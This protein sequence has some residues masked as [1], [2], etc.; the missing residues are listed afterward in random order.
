MSC[1]DR[2]G[3][4]EARV[5]TMVDRLTLPRVIGASL[6]LLAVL[7]VIGWA[8]R[9]DPGEKPYLKVLGGGF[10]FNY[11]IAEVYYGFTAVV[12]KPL[13]SGSIIEA[14]FEDPAGGAPHTVRTRVT[15]RTTTYSLR[16]PPV[17]GVEKG[18]PYTVA[19][20]ILDRRGSSELWQHEMTIRSQIGDAV[21]PDVP[22]VIGPGYTP[23]PLR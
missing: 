15:P 16:S 19:V 4:I 10:I 9:I 12:Q 5:E 6:V 17:R 18:H 14:I 22:L 21:V 23:N 11:R 3:A 8:T 20:R 13:Q 1:Y 7:M 2:V